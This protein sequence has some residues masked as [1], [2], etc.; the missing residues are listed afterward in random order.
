[1]L[2]VLK[3]RKFSTPKSSTRIFALPSNVFVNYLYAC[4]PTRKNLVVQHY[5]MHEHL[6]SW[7]M[8]N[9]AA[10]DIL[11][12]QGR[13]CHS[14]TAPVLTQCLAHPKAGWD[15]KIPWNPFILAGQ[16]TSGQH[17]FIPWM[18]TALHHPC[19]NAIFNSVI[20]RRLFSL[21]YPSTENSS[22]CFIT[23]SFLGVS[24]SA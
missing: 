5:M 18:S 11:A 2:A 4:V 16:Y 21:P 14:S 13:Q 23:S 10:F 20:S 9:P 1:M 19:E 15:W 8:G 17:F 3:L 6:A 7:G 24:V 22:C 12:T